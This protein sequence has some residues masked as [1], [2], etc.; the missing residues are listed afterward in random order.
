ML[1]LGNVVILATKMVEARGWGWIWVPDARGVV[2][3]DGLRL[4]VAVALEM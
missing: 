1:D 2:S 3:C 4:V